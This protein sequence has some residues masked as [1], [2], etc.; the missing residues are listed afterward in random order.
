MSVAARRILSR[1]PVLAALC[2]CG[3]VIVAQDACVLAEPSGDLPRLPDSRPTILHASLVPS[4]SAVLSR[5]PSSFVVP[6]ELADPTAT[7][8][9]AAFID[10]NPF[11]NA[12][13]VQGPS[14]SDREPNAPGR[15]RILTVAVPAPPDIDRCHVIEIVVALRF[16]SENDSK[17]VHTPAEPGGDI[18]TWFYS[19]NGDLAGCPTLDAGIDAAVDADAAEGG[20]Q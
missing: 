14:H 12:G 20:I 19:P 16:S 2:V 10:Y 17:G 13:L 11:T 3:V 18:A 1:V 4:A 9:Y 6:V 15:T 7:L 8:G 5:F